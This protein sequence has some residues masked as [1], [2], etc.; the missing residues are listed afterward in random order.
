MNRIDE[1]FRNLKSENKKALIMFL[2]AGDPDFNWTKKIV[3]NVCKAGADIVELGIPYSDPL[4]DGPV[5]QNS[6]QRALENGAKIVDI[7]NCASQIRKNTEVPLVYLVYYN[8]IFKYGIENFLKDSSKSGIDGI[9]IPDLPVEE[10]KSIIDVSL[11]FNIHLIP[12]VAPTSKKRI[13][14]IVTS[15]GGF[16][17]CVSKN[18]VTGIDESIKTDMKEYMDMIEEYTQL[19]KAIGFGIKNSEMASKLKNYCDGVILGSAFVDM[20]DK[21]N[22][23]DEAI[24][25]TVKFTRELRKSI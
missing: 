21:S 12:L 5:I 25:N 2:T 14:S 19:P 7:M 13:K 16:V 20:I 4:A 23:I 1:K 18:G 6:S 3:L 22:D 15:G 17:Y 24:K 10:R 8:S 9:I 11:K